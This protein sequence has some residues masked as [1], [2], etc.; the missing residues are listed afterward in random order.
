MASVTELA[1]TLT[2]AK[3]IISTNFPV[4]KRNDRR[5]KNKCSLMRWQNTAGITKQSF[6]HFALIHAHISHLLNLNTVISLTVVL[7]LDEKENKN[8]QQA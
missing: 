5:I 2:T 7:M 4:I 6:I 1:Y 3:R 8:N